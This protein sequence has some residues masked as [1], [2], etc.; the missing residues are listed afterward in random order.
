MGRDLFPPGAAVAVNLRTLDGDRVFYRAETSAH[1]APP[2][3]QMVEV[4]A[5]EPG[6]PLPTPQRF[7]VPRRQLTRWEGQTSSP[8]HD[9]LRLTHA[10]MMTAVA[11]RQVPTLLSL[12]E[13]TRTLPDDE[14]RWPLDPLI[15]QFWRH[16]TSLAVNQLLENGLQGA[17]LRNVD[18]PL[19]DWP[20]LDLI[21]MAPAEGDLTRSVGDPRQWSLGA[22]LLA[23]LKTA[24]SGVGMLQAPAPDVQLPAATNPA[25]R[26]FA[27]LAKIVAT[28]RVRDLLYPDPAPQLPVGPSQFGTAALT[29]RED[30]EKAADSRRRLREIRRGRHEATSADDLQVEAEHVAAMRRWG[31][32]RPMPNQLVPGDVSWIRTWHLHGRSSESLRAAIVGKFPQ[33]SHVNPTPPYVNAVPYFIPSGATQMLEAEPPPPELAEQL[34]MPHNEM[35][36]VWADPLELDRTE[37]VSWATASLHLPEVWAPMSGKI[38]QLRMCRKHHLIGALLLADPVTRRPDEV[39]LLA[40][41]EDR[42]ITWDGHSPELTVDNYLGLATM[43][44]NHWQTSDLAGLVDNILALVDYSLWDEP[45]PVDL[46]PAGKARKKALRSSKVRKELLRGAGVDR[47]RVMALGRTAAKQARSSS[48]S[49]GTPK[50]PHLRRGH[51]RR[52]RVGPHEAPWHEVRYVGPT[53]VNSDLLGE[54]ERPHGR[55]I[56]MVPKRHART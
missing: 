45:Q 29:S 23:F 55:T 6:S 44:A 27:P 42:F 16:A 37:T 56:W 39:I 17:K 13:W 14:L 53:I 51:W 25:E 19:L 36:V 9:G 31:P 15:P 8:F 38:Q 33:L 11:E 3:L 22:L 18:E 12:L 47:M 1:A 2:F 54:G 20:V 32:G 26:A 48:S 24:L 41:T 28:W 5:R 34:L 21:D 43:D 50:R 10:S 40:A 52:Q 35:L 30:T 49:S 46:P 7:A 4:T